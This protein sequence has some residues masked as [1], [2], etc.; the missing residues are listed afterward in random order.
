MLIPL[1]GPVGAAVSTVLAYGVQAALVLAFLWREIH[2]RR[3]L[4]PYVESAAAA[5]LLAL[6]LVVLPGPLLLQLAAG[7]VVYVVAWYVLARRF[8]PDQVAV[9]RRLLPGVRG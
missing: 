1:L 7:A 8:A 6:T 4:R 2:L 9:L 3:L 5:A